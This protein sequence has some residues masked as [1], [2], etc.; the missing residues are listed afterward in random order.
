MHPEAKDKN[1]HCVQVG[2]ADRSDAAPWQW[3]KKLSLSMAHVR[4][5]SLHDNISRF[6]PDF[7]VE[8]RYRR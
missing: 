2:V 4:R 3:G 1:P 5:T 7:T 6:S 8:W